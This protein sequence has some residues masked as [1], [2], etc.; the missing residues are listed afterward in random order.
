MT[1]LIA[2]AEPHAARLW[3]EACAREGLG[4][5]IAGGTDEAIAVLRDLEL[6]AAVIALDARGGVDA[7]TVATLVAYRQPGVPVVLMIGPGIQPDGSLQALLP[8]VR[9]Y[10]SY[11]TRPGDL[12]ALVMHSA[13]RP[14]H[15]TAR[16]R[17]PLHPPAC[18][19]H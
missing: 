4:T 2:C 8:N 19:L 11:A 15:V 10:L 9:A 6:G 14:D 5:R 16:P 13:D 12:A 17:Q 3:A 18:A 7:L 1:V